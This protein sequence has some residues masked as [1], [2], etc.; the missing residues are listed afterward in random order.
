MLNP[1]KK[2][3][4]L[5]LP[6][7]GNGG[8]ER[9]ILRLFNHLSSQG[10]EVK[11]LVASRKGRLV[12]NVNIDIVYLDSKFSL[13][14]ILKYIKY[15]NIFKPDIILSTLSS[16]IIISGLASLITRKKSYVLIMRVANIINMRDMNPLR[17]ILESFVLNFSDGIIC[18]SR[19]TAKSVKKLLILRKNKNSMKV[20]SNPVLD[21]NFKTIISDHK[22]EEKKYKQLIFIGRLVPQ[23]Q[24]KDTIRAFEII[25]SQLKNVKLTIIGEGLEFKETRQLIEKLGLQDKVT[26]KPYCN[27]IP[28]LLMN[29][30]CLI[31][32]SKFEG[33]GNIFIEGIAF[34]DYLVCYDSP[35]GAN[36]I[37]KMTTEANIIKQGDISSLAN[38]VISLLS[39]EEPSKKNFKFLENFTQSKICSTYENYL[40]N[41]NK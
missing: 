14:S 16:A 15:I 24:V 21:D 30:D 34:C 26:I 23:K 33:F 9:V 7:L 37:L 5:F 28:S 13:L 6:G 22:K 32:T 35:G 18:N 12:D 27:N 25:N 2:K 1:D 10:H 40:M 17:L 8:A 3:F 41:I 38:K 20:I 29:S 36:E 11:L 19:A 4:I 31:N 39:G